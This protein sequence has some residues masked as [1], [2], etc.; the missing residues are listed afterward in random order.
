MVPAKKGD[1][2]FVFGINHNLQQGGGG[3]AK[4]DYKLQGGMTVTEGLP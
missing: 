2:V 4:V 1:Y 3:H